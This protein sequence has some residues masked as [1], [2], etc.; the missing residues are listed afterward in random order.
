MVC[1][2]VSNPFE[3]WFIINR[4]T[5]YWLIH[6][7]SKFHVYPSFHTVCD[8]LINKKDD[9]EFEI[10]LLRPVKFSEKQHAACSAIS[11]VFFLFVNSGRRI[12]TY[13]NVSIGC[14]R[15][16]RHTRNGVGRDDENEIFDGDRERRRRR[17]H[18]ESSC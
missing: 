2:Y 12:L 9:D 17:L 3:F 16:Q 11:T 15:L 4:L 7:P 1:K 13:F 18:E 10:I 6:F 5:D 14:N 8:N